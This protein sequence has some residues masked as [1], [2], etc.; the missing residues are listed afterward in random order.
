MSI[1][2]NQGHNRRAPDNGVLYSRKKNE[3]V[4]C[5]DVETAPRNKVRGSV[6]AEAFGRHPW[7]PWPWPRLFSLPSPS[8]QEK[9]KALTT[10]C[11]VEAL[12]LSISAFICQICSAFLSVFAW[13]HTVFLFLWLSTMPS[14]FVH[15]V[16]YCKI[17]KTEWLILFVD[18]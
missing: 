1:S 5:S 18:F 8:P 7:E 2:K 15:V 12:S 16:A 11:R 6:C 14:S 9:E 4:L 10:G 3:E 17:I 13:N